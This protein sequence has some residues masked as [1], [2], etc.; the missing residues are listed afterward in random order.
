M[1][2]DLALDGPGV[3]SFNSISTLEKYLSSPPELV[4]EVLPPELVSPL[5][6]PEKYDLI[7]SNKLDILDVV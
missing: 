6:P 1:Y 3:L 7:V 4:K 2:L 5:P